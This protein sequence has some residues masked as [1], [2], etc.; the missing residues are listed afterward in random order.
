MS[1]FINTFN[2][3][4]SELKVESDDNVLLW[5]RLR[6]NDSNQWYR[7]QSKVVLWDETTRSEEVTIE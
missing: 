4:L 3:E 6:S 5:E 7:T 2:K 1:F